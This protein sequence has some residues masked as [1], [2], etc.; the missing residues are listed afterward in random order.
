MA[1]WQAPNRGGKPMYGKIEDP[2][3]D[4]RM[5]ANVRYHAS[6]GTEAIST[7]IRQ[8]EGEWDMERAVTAALS[9]VGVLGLIMGFFGGRI[10]KLLAWVSIPS[11]L[12]FSLGKW[13]P[14]ASVLSR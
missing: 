6:S 14:T 5:S 8:L 2:A 3:I 12:A 7:R 9:G 11:L 1:N 10:L 4:T 13:A